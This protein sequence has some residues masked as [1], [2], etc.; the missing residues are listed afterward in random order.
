MNGAI[1]LGMGKDIK[2][3]AAMGTCYRFTIEHAN[4]HNIH[5]K[6]DIN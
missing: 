6:T 4:T 3:I 5:N 1:L 2:Q